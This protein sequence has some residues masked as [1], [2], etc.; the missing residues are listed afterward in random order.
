M[1]LPALL[2]QKE[3][4][5]SSDSEVESK[6]SG[7]KVLLNDISGEAREGEIMGVLGASGSDKSTLIDTLADR[8]LKGSLK[9]SVTLNNEVLELMSLKLI[10]F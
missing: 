5:G 1:K 9:G 4:H 2:C 10:S 3:E 8:I 6:D 7:M